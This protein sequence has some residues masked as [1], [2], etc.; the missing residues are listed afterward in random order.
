[1]ETDQLE[2]QTEK[3]RRSTGMTTYLSNLE[4]ANEEERTE[5]EARV[6]VEDTGNV[7]EKEMAKSSLPIKH[8]DEVTSM[9]TGKFESILKRAENLNTEATVESTN[10]EWKKLTKPNLISIPYPVSMTKEEEDKLL[11]ET[12]R[13]SD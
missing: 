3:P 13:A 6:A 7:D 11:E 1:M 2:D 4:I 8:W 9:N 12:R 5:A 10:S